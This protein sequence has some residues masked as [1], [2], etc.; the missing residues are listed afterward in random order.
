[1]NS[2]DFT[3]RISNDIQVKKTQNGKSVTNISLAVKRNRDTTD[4]VSI[5]LWGTSADYIG[6]YAKK[7]DLIGIYNVL[8]FLFVEDQFSTIALFQKL[9]Q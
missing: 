9:Q 1:M 2:C 7:G 8:L 3:G 6:Q 4:F 5:V